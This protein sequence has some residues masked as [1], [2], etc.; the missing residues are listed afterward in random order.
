MEQVSDLRFGIVSKITCQGGNNEFE[1]RVEI[2]ATTFRQVVE[3]LTLPCGLN[4]LVKRVYDRSLDTVL[5]V[6]QLAWKFL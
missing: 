2:C 5:L 1:A 3:N 6:F 4:V